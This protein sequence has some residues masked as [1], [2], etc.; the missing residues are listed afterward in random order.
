VTREEARRILM[1]YRPDVPETSDLALTEAL[2][3]AKRDPELMIWL[4]KHLAWQRSLGRKLRSLP[5]P[6]ELLPQ[7]LA[8]RQTIQIAR[9]KRPSVLL[10][11]A[12]LFLLLGL[13]AKLV[14]FNPAPNHFQN[15]QSRMVSSVL[16][17]YSM[18]IVT[19][20]LEAV[21]QFMAHHEAP[22]TFEIPAPLTNLNLTGGGL[23]RWRNHPVSMICYDRGTNQMVFLFVMNRQAP[24]DP[25]SRA[26]RI[27]TVNKLT[28]AS[29]TRGEWVY[30]M[31]AEPSPEFPKK[32]LPSRQE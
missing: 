3:L 1:L 24:L 25:P 18:D 23:L 7:I 11:A 21:R 15:F 16:R 8:A 29:W 10:S 27:R 13:I 6:E 12:A 22:A 17:E 20:Q 14:M 30:L 9:W 31:A 32:Y 28:T 19:N 4:E 2:A 26:P 5:V